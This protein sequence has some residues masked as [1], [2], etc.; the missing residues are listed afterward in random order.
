[1]KEYT[2]IICILDRSGSMS[3]II[4]ESI[5]GFNKFV[6]LQKELEGEATLR[7]HMFDTTW[8]T[9]SETR[10][11]YLIKETNIQNVEPIN[12]NQYSPEGGTPLYDA[13]GFIIYD[14][15]DWLGNTPLEE[16][17]EKTLCIILTDGEENSSTVWNNEQIKNLIQ[18]CREELNWEF[19]YLGA[20]QDACFVAQNMGMSSGNAYTYAATG[21]GANDAYD[22]I[23]V[24]TT[25]FRKSKKGDNT[26]NLIEDK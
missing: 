17:P 25:S 11:E 9:S 24:A 22:K 12:R 7:A 16:R 18:E 2:K 1:M 20:N 10:I 23:T 5:T 15:L 13:I 19:I 21:E 6:N 8:E 14:E 26:E 4:N 3:S